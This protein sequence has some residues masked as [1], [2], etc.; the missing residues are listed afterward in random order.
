MGK[1]K[2]SSLSEDEPG[3]KKELRSWAKGEKKS[4]KQHGWERRKGQLEDSGGKN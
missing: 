3:G 4:H 1:K 2:K